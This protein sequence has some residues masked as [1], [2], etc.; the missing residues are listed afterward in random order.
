MRATRG[1]EVA[2][3]ARLTRGV[4]AAELLAERDPDW[5]DLSSTFAFTCGD[6]LIH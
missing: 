6:S 1:A 5:R 3:L 4:Q 2:G